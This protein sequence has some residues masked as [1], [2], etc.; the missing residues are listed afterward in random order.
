LKRKAVNYSKGFDLKLTPEVLE[1][2]EQVVHKSRDKFTADIAGRLSA[3]RRTVAEDHDRPDRHPEL[4]TVVAGA[5]LEIK[6]AGGTIGF[7]LLT[8]LGKSLNDFVDGL[9][10]LTD[11]QLVVISLHIDAMYAILANRIMGSGGKVEAEIVA[12]FEE[13]CRKFRDDE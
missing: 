1:K 5:S 9:E 12:A 13:A 6:G 10:R 3:M 7:D 4:I 8:R 2:L 11:R